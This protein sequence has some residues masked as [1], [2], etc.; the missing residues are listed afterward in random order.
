VSSLKSQTAL[1]QFRDFF[2]TEGH[3]PPHA[4]VAGPT[5]PAVDFCLQIA[6]AN[7]AFGWARCCCCCC[8]CRAAGPGSPSRKP[9][10]LRQLRGVLADIAYI[11][12]W[13]QRSM[14]G[15]ALCRSIASGGS[16]FWAIRILLQ[17][18][19]RTLLTDWAWGPG[20]RSSLQR[21]FGPW[22]SGERRTEGQGGGVETKKEK[23]LFSSICLSL[24]S[25]RETQYVVCV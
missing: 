12:H 18:T 1:Q 24:F 10:L 7:V 14:E 11:S 25:S 13:S 8:C 5:Y 22:M 9:T 21:P 15:F 23:C 2:I 4:L 6:G 19:W 3:P 20:V 17:G 16:D